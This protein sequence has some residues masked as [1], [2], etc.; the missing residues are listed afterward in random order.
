MADANG[1]ERIL[2]IEPEGDIAFVLS[3]LLGDEGYRPEVV[4]SFPPAH[5]ISIDREV[6]MV[7]VDVYSPAGVDLTVVNRLLSALVGRELPVLC[8]S[9]DLRGASELI[10]KPNV[11]GVI[12]MPFDIDALLR[13]VRAILDEGK[14]TGNPGLNGRAA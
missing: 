1:G 11:R 4:A 7:I 10:V 12:E 5:P 13:K 3:S 9:T 14:N 2:V 6:D 8:M